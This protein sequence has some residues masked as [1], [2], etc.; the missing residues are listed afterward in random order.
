[1]ILPRVPGAL[2][3]GLLASLAA[4]TALYGHE[5]AMA[6]GYHPQL[7]LTAIV[8]VLGFLVGFG[9]LAWSARNGPAQGSILASRL[10][11]R[12]PGF[13]LVL[14]AAALWFSLAEAI[15][16][17]HASV[18]PVV[19][20]LCLC[21]AAWAVGLLAHAVVAALAGIV[22]AI[23]RLAFAPRTPRWSRRRAASPIRRAAPFARRLFARPP[24]VFALLRA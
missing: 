9:A 1:M 17:S 18:L 8:G 15:E 14:A 20:L 24:P 13:G 21:V 16:P 22:I 12:L 10:S 19:T 6:G 23:A 4:H 3:L 5:H 2:A 7:V 11:E